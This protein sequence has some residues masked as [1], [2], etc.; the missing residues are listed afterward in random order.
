LK[1]MPEQ[2]F[3]DWWAKEKAP[4]LKQEIHAEEKHDA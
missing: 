2:S 3:R 4:H 1:A